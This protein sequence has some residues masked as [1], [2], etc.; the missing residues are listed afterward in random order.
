MGGKT[1]SRVVGRLDALTVKGAKL[2]KGKRKHML[3]DGGC[4][5]L[6][7]VQGKEGLCKSWLF[8][9]QLNHRRRFMGL[10][11]T[12]TVSLAEAREKARE[13]RKNLI[14]GIDPLEVRNERK[15]AAIAERAKAV[16]FEQCAR[17]Y[18]K[19]HADGCAG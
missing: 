17:S 19:L 1:L 5:Y 7:I 3:P 18:I 15:R 4:L 8:N 13:Y 6:E 9:Y 2:P 12:H 10:G 14:D 11:P 16:T